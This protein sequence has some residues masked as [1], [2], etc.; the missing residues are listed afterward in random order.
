MNRRPGKPEVSPA[1]LLS[2]ERGVRY[3]RLSVALCAAL[4][5]VA[6]PLPMAAGAD[7]LIE[8]PD[9]AS[10]RYT[11][12]YSVR[13]DATPEV[14]WTH[15]TDLGAWMYDFEMSHVAG[16]PGE[17]GEVLRLYPDQ[18][19]LVQVVK[20]V[21]G[22]LLVVANLPSTFG[23]E[24]STGTVVVALHESEGVTEVRL[25]MSRRYTW[26]G[27]GPN[28]LRARRGSPEFAEETRALWQDRFLERLRSLAEAN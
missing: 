27:D 28:P 26:Q 18:D 22:R 10:Y 14:V 9:A 12:H 24:F 19:F 20:I 25:T 3:R 17:E 16:Q 21:P 4:L 13:I 15:L 2:I 8:E 1:A 6:F 23:G 7:S 11:S 5:L